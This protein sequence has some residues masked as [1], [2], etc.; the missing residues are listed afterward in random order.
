MSGAAGIAAAKNRR[1]KTDNTSRFASS[2][3]V[4]CSS[5]KN[6]AC[7][8]PQ[9]K[10]LQPP[11]PVS[12]RNVNNNITKST[13]DNNLVDPN[14]LQILGPL[15]PAQ[16]LKYHEQ[17]LNRLDE[18][19]RQTRPV[20]HDTDEADEEYREEC[21]ARI[22]TLESKLSMLE[23]VI[24]NLQNKLTVAQN[25]MMETNLEVS[26]LKCVQ[27]YSAPL[28]PTVSEE[29]NMYMT[30]SELANIELANIANNELPISELL[31]SELPVS[32]LPVSDNTE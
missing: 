4:S 2:S 29:I 22:G 31:I 6:G 26:K 18:Q 13:N 9:N 7:P 1:S 27:V 19:L 28:S 16:I 24:M 8:M 12:T 15:P 5:N 32:E 14:T 25:F 11:V 21:F 10:K 23:E 17:R 30:V 20:V 3:A